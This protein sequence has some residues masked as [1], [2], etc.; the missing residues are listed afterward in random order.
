MKSG[1]IKFTYQSTLTFI[2]SRRK[3]QTESTYLFDT[4]A[5]TN[6]CPSI[7]DFEESIIQLLPREYIG[8]TKLCKV[9]ILCKTVFVP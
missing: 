4:N 1:I 8:Y 7:T 2:Y 5:E 3:L 9:T 6:I